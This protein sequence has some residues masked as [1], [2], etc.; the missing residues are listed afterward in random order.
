[1]DV[2]IYADKPKRPGERN[3][4][5]SNVNKWERVQGPRFKVQRLGRGEPDGGRNETRVENHGED[6]RGSN[7]AEGHA[8]QARG[9]AFGTRDMRRPFH[10]AYSSTWMNMPL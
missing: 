6:G 1:M 3:E 10:R 5:S 9:G 2:R 7:F 4:V 8:G